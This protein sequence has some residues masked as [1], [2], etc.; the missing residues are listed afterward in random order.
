MPLF[1]PGNNNQ[2]TLTLYGYILT[3]GRPP[4]LAN[5]LTS[6]NYV[7]TQISTN[8]SSLHST[9]T[10]TLASGYLALS[11]GTMSGSINMNGQRIQNVAVAAASDAASAAWVQ[12]T[13][14]GY[15]AAGGSY[16]RQIWISTG[17]PSGGNSGDIW[18]QY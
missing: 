10:T 14:Y 2:G 9:I 8:I 13:G 7:D 1:L 6:K 5:Q 15:Q 18:I 11:G 3:D 16:T 12:S 17:G 4:T